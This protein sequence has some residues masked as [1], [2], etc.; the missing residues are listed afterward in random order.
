MKNV[1]LI[2]LGVIPALVRAWELGESFACVQKKGQA[3]RCGIL[4]NFLYREKRQYYHT[5]TDTPMGTDIVKIVWGKKDL[6]WRLQMYLGKGS[7][8]MKWYTTFTNTGSKNQHPLETD[9]WQPVEGREDLIGPTLGLLDKDNN[10]TF[11][12]EKQP[13]VSNI[14]ERLGFVAPALRQPKKKE[15]RGPPHQLRPPMPKTKPAPL[16]KVDLTTNKPDNAPKKNLCANCQKEAIKMY[17]VSPCHDRCFICSECPIEIL[18]KGCPICR[19]TVGNLG[20]A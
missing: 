3:V 20:P 15:S 11:S 5:D 1:L 17:E 10:P 13:L 4:G 7:G 9:N 14:A 19:K 16:P 6:R 12:F 18:S 8:K 2:S